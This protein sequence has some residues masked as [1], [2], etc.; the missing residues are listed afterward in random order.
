[1]GFSRLLEDSKVSEQPPQDDEN[2]YSHA[3][4]AACELSRSISGGD[5]AQQFAH[6]VSGEGKRVR[7]CAGGIP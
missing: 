7:Q 4:A 3:S 6:L 1:L 2:D 5:A